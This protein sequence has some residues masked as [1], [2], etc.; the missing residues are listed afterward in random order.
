MIYTTDMGFATE[1]GNVAPIS[2]IDAIMDI[3]ESALEYNETSFLYEGAVGD[4]ATGAKNFVRNLGSRIVNA[5]NGLI[6]KVKNMIMDKAF[7]N[8]ER[9]INNY[10]RGKK[11]VNLGSG[12]E[13]EF[14]AFTGKGEI[15]V[16]NIQSIADSVRK[17]D[18]KVSDAKAEVSDAL[19]DDNNYT[20]NSY[21]NLDS[22]RKA[23]GDIKDTSKALVSGLETMKK[24]ALNGLK[25]ASDATGASNYAAF[26][27][28]AANNLTNRSLSQC[29]KCIN[30]LNRRFGKAPKKDK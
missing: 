7:K 20:K 22:A 9:N 24:G 1:S 6:Q 4:A 29:I 14:L 5:I 28:W 10:M 11:E 27:V 3:Y 21:D 8:L 12:Q 17:G 25:G 18:K 16:A 15:S 26:V 19:K 23:I 30:S 2:A 13:I